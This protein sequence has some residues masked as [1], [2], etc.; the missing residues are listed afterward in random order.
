ML[1]VRPES[2]KLGDSG[3]AAAVIAREFKGHDLTYTLE[4]GN[5]QLVV[6]TDHTKVLQVGELTF[7][8]LAGEAV[9]VRGSEKS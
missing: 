7:V 4:A 2:L 6:Q 9:V 5:V 8:K 1:S 3:L